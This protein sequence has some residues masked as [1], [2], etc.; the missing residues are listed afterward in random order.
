MPN[1]HQSPSTDDD[2]STVKACRDCGEP[3][4]IVC[5]HR[6]GRNKPRRADCDTC[7]RATVRKYRNRNKPVQAGDQ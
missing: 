2:H 1:Q 3:K 7:R 4:N 6:Q 5:F